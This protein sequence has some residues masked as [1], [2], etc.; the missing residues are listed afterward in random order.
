MMLRYCISPNHRLRFGCVQEHLSNISVINPP[1]KYIKR[2][3]SICE[4]KDCHI[5]RNLEN[6][7]RSYDTGSICRIC[8]NWMKRLT[9]WRKVERETPSIRVRELIEIYENKL[10]M[11]VNDGKRIQKKRSTE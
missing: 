11:E 1:V 8:F 9:F 10:R 5:Q 4:E 6:Y 3:C 2:E 7:S